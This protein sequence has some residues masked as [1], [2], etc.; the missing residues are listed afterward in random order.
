[1]PGRFFQLVA[2]GLCL[3]AGLAGTGG[4][5]SS[6]ARLSAA[7]RRPVAV[8][9]SAPPP[10]APALV[11]ARPAS[12]ATAASLAAGAPAGTT[13]RYERNASVR[14]LARQGEAAGRAGEQGVVILDFGR[15]AEL[16]GYPGTMAVRGG[17][18]HLTAIVAAVEAYAGA[19]FRFAPVDTALYLAIGTNNS[20]TPGAPCG[21]VV[22]G[23]RD[24]PANLY[25]W[26]QAL[27]EAVDSVRGYVATLRYEEGFTDDVEVVAG[28]DAE[29]AFDPGF[30]NTYDVLSGYASIVGPHGAPMVDYGSA[31]PHYWSP[32][33]LLQVAFG[34]GTDVAMPEIYYPVEAGEW[35]ALLTFAKSRLG[36]VLDIQ[37]VLAD[38]RG[39]AAAAS[40]GEL[41][42]AIEAVTS[43]QRIPWLSTMAA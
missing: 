29:P 15:P 19:Y 11:A 28:D 7:T 2:S 8:H 23:C 10:T 16:G 21:A 13:S 36:E 14:A 42:S 38:R 4:A 41:L 33:Q 22:C 32:Q 1:M 31:E 40:Y 3:A 9:P 18:V 26:G 12:T 27:A 6:A 24:E 25:L 37:G 35:A 30:T 43:Q 34:F 20:C 17:F 39:A 5:A